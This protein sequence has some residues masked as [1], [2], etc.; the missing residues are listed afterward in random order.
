MFSERSYQA[1]AHSS[2]PH[3]EESPST[4][5][6]L[7]PLAVR[8]TYINMVST[9]LPNGVFVEEGSIDSPVNL[10]YFRSRRNILKAYISLAMS[11]QPVQSSSNSTKT[12]TLDVFE[13]GPSF[14]ASLVPEVREQPSPDHQR[15]ER[16][17]HRTAGSP[18]RLKSTW[19]HQRFQ[20]PFA[21]TPSP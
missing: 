10:K 2:Y 16:H 5:H 1:V 4:R 18:R 17:H 3:Q 19:R 14:A 7:F 13:T 21:Q 20:R 9:I 11:P 12:A 8:A 6:G 15:A